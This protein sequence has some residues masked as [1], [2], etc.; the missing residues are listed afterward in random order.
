MAEEPREPEKRP[1]VRP[2]FWVIVL[3]LLAINMF[4]TFTVESISWQAHLGGLVTGML[5][6]AGYAYSPR[7]Q[8]T[9]LHVGAV[10]VLLVLATVFTVVRTGQLT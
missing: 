1:R 2:R 5:M 10:S 7:E 9:V 6:G 3:V 8:R 4:I